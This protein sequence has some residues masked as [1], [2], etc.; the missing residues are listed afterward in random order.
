MERIENTLFHIEKSAWMH[1]GEVIQ[2]D[3]QEVHTAH[4]NEY[5][6]FNILICTVKKGRGFT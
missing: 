1:S 3:K 2:V 6:K 5:L 4:Q